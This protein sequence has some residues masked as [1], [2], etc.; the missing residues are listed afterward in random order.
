MKKLIV[1]IFLIFLLVMAFFRYQDYTRLNAP[2]DYG[3]VINAE[4]D[5]NYHDQVLVKEYYKIAYE[6]GSFAREQWFNHKIDVLYQDNESKE[7]QRATKAYNQMLS[8]VSQIEAQLIKSANLKKQGFSNR[9]IKLMQDE[10]LST[11]EY[12]LN[13]S[14]SSLILKHGDQ[15]P[16]VMEM[17]KRL[18]KEGHVLLIDGIFDN[19][20]MGV[21][22][23]FQQ[24]NGLFPSGIT[25]KQ[26]LLLLFKDIN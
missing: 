7:S 5:N 18:S 16:N 15:G 25:D 4:I 6:I 8:A 19:E 17:Q 1:S 24:N 3:Y 2:N 14:L 10:G 23:E 26:M 9:E 11:K 20:T 13:N 12:T 22:M 21:V